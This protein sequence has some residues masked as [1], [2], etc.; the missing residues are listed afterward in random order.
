MN[1][2]T[3]YSVAT[4]EEDSREWLEAP[5]F[6]A[7]SSPICLSVKNH[8]TILETQESACKWLVV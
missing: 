8:R 4:V 1:Y 2:I 6:E 7:L 5:H 3:F